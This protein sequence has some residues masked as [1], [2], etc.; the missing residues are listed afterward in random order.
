MIPSAVYVH[1]NQ[2]H[3]CLCVHVCKHPR[4]KW[5]THTCRAVPSSTQ[6]LC[7]LQDNDT[8]SSLS[9]TV[10]LFSCPQRSLIS[11]DLPPVC[12]RKERLHC[13]A[14]SW[15]LNSLQAL[16]ANPTTSWLSS[17]CLWVWGC[18][19]RHA[20]LLPLPD[21]LWTR[22]EQILA[23]AGSI[24]QLPTSAPSLFSRNYI[25]HFYFKHISCQSSSPKTLISRCSH[26]PH[27]GR[28]FSTG[29]CLL[30]HRKGEISF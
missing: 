18:L 19:Y 28:A 21:L 11:S 9:I 24:A 29:I 23:Q 2:P 15:C 12:I 6:A 10:F 4:W 13:P 5:G 1:R 3:E 14:H 7:R 17:W 30:K 8:I 27:H 26:S 22:R 25:L 20:H 16:G